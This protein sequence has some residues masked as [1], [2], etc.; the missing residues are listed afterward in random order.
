VVQHSFENARPSHQPRVDRSLVLADGRRL[1]VAEWGAADGP[2]T[3]FFHGRPGSRLICP[4]AT[5]TEHAGVRF[6]SFDRP[7]YG[8]SDPAS[9]PLLRRDVVTD[10]VE[11][12]DQLGIDRAA[13][14][15]W[16]GGGPFALA[17]GALIP[18]RVV[19]TAVMCSPGRPDTE[20]DVSAEVWALA[21][22]AAIDPDGH[23]DLVRARCRWLADDP[24]ELLRLTERFSPAT[25]TAPGM[26]DAF[27][28]WMEEAAAVSIEGYVQDWMMEC[29]ED[30]WG[31]DLRDVA[32]PVFCWS[33]D[34]DRLIPPLHAQLLAGRLRDCRTYACPECGHFVPVAH[35]PE[36]LEQLLHA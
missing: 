28:A 30:G 18:D 32:G 9:P 26:R 31:F 3:V 22:A 7:G 1:Q 16:S 17:C 14:A 19:A 33:G 4:D 8:R 34:Q 25:L 13:M 29:Y 12:L 27:V 5:A 11:M 36:I 15:G 10:V 21:Q 6:V 35:W 23:R 20:A 24:H 2:A